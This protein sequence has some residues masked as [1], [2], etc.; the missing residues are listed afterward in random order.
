[1]MVHVAHQHGVH[2]HFFKTG[3][4]CGINTS[5]YLLKFVL[6]GNGVKLA[7]IKAVDAD[8]QRR[9][10]RFAPGSGIPRQTVPVGGYRNLTDSVIFTHGGDDVGKV[11]TQGRF[12][13]RQTHFFRSQAG[14]RTCDT[15]NFINGQKAVIGN[16]AGLIAIRQTVG[17]TKVTHIG[18][19]QT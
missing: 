10:S 9:E 4:K 7:S 3:I 1:M 15:T 13:S 14:E 19:R 12:A 11:A 16:A 6:S 8:V 5:H 2:F 18:N 17:A